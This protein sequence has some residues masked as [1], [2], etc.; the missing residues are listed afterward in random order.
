VKVI[1]EFD[2]K[3]NVRRLKLLPSNGY[4][5]LGRICV[6]CRPNI[7]H[8]QRASNC[9]TKVRSNATTMKPSFHFTARSQDLLVNIVP[10]LVEISSPLL[11]LT[12][13]LSSLEPMLGPIHPINSLVPYICLRSSLVDTRSWGAMLQTERSQFRIPKQSL[14]FLNSPYPFCLTMGLSSTQSLTGM[15]TRRYFWG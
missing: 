5:K 4:R 6:L 9:I 2:E 14:N 11:A 12:D 15:G 3:G 10:E 13:L 7:I 1:P 8:N